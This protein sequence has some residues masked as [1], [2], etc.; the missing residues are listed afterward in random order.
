MEL[1]CNGR[2]LDGLTAGIRKSLK[3]L[4]IEYDFRGLLYCRDGSVINVICSL[5]KMLYKNGKLLSYLQKYC[6]CQT[7]FRTSLLKDL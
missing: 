5:S 6:N 7:G 3:S 1:E 4:D 2:P